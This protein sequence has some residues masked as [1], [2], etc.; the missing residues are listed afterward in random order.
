MLIFFFTCFSPLF[1]R[2]IHLETAESRNYT[3][4]HTVEMPYCASDL[5]LNLSNS[6]LSDSPDISQGGIEGTGGA[7]LL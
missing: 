6:A 2:K 7:H 1:Q 4:C 5:P 3:L